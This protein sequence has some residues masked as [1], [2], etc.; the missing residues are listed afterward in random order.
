MR[1]ARIRDKMMNTLINEDIYKRRKEAVR[2]GQQLDSHCRS[3][4]GRNDLNALGHLG[5]MTL[6]LNIDVQLSNIRNK[7]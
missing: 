6:L 1:P 7:K 3:M 2:I 5:I 4:Q